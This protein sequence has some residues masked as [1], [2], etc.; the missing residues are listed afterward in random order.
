MCLRANAAMRFRSSNPGGEQIRIGLRSR[1]HLVPLKKTRLGTPTTTTTTTGICG[2]WSFMGLAL[3]F[4]GLPS[5]LPTAG[6]LCVFRFRTK[7][8]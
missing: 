1:L 3:L 6:A 2:T 4:F 7:R 8:Q 5:P